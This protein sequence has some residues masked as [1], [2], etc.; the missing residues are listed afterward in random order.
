MFQPQI[1]EDG[2]THTQ[3]RNF[4]GFF[5]FKTFKFQDFS[6]YCAWF[7]EFITRN[8]KTVVSYF[9]LKACLVPRKN[10]KLNNSVK[11]LKRKRHLRNVSNRPYTFWRPIHG[12][13]FM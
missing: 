5:F 9:L 4:N 12:V 3:N 2:K 13:I 1:K 11:F 10:G 6:F 8:V 7:K